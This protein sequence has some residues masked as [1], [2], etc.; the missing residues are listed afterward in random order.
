[1]NRTMRSV[2][3]GLAVLTL[4]WIGSRVEAG[5]E[6]SVN[7][8]FAHSSGCS[9]CAYQ[10]PIIREFES[11]HPEVNVSWV[12][13]HDLDSDQRKLIEGTSGHPVMVFHDGCVIRRIAGE[14]SVEALEGEYKTF[15]DQVATT[16]C[17]RST[18]GSGIVCRPRW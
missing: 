2:L 8:L 9:H 3:V 11:R 13:Y 10:R 7:L 6:P 18:T 4:S 17:Q 1:M 12:G 16:Q 15:K 14:T 5:Q